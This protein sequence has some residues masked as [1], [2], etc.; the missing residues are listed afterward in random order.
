[1]PVHHNQTPD[2]A[3]AAA[4][5]TVH[6]QAPETMSS[7]ELRMALQ[8]ER[9]RRLR[10]LNDAAES[11]LVPIQQVLDGETAR[12]GNLARALSTVVPRMQRRFPALDAEIA[13]FCADALDDARNA[14]VSAG[15]KTA[16]L[17]E[18]LATDTRPGDPD[19]SEIVAGG[20]PVPDD[21]D[22]W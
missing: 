6:G 5:P 3:L 4:D 18:A 2:Y 7:P 8:A 20:T 16:A 15:R 13:S 12:V 1:M 22:E 9:L 10:I 19:G 11:G 21:D 14:F 17:A